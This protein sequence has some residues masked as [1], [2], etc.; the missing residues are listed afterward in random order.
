[1]TDSELSA[2]LRERVAGVRS[3]I[4]AACARVNRNPDGVTLVAVTK[5]VSPRV[6]R[7]IAELGVV[8]LGESRPQEL[9]RKAEAL[10]DLPIRWH[11]VGHLQRNKVERTLP[12]VHLIHSVDSLRLYE[13]IQDEAAKQRRRRPEILLQMNISREGQKHGFD[14]EELRREQAKFEPMFADPPQ[15]LPRLPVVG[16][17]GMAAYSDNP[18]NARPAF[19][20]LHL[21]RYRLSEEWLVVGPQLEHLS[22]GMSGDFEV[23]IEEGATIVRIGTTLFEGLENE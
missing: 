11:L 20:E 22:M 5:T 12:L 21:I 3:R 10:K 18:E 4:A 1:M 23:A 8:D 9:W 17:M 7:Q 19:R 13:A 14:Y 15:E 2:V 16:L 6:A